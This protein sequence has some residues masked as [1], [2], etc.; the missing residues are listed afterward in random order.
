MYI[1]NAETEKMI[2]DNEKSDFKNMM[3]LIKNLNANSPYNLISGNG[4]RTRYPRYEIDN[5]Y[6][7]DDCE[8]TVELF[9]EDIC[10][11][12]FISDNE[13]CFQNLQ[14]D[15]EVKLTAENIIALANYFKKEFGIEGE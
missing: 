14:K 8:Q 13:V 12:I 2:R 6:E 10:N 9:Q 5:I 15:H 4:S 7:N 3:R 11:H 1:V